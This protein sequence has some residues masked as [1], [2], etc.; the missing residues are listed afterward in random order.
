MDELIDIVNN[1]DDY[2]IL[3]NDIVNRIEQTNNNI[4]MIKESAILNIYWNIGETL[5]EMGSTSEEDLK[6]IRDDPLLCHV[7]TNTHWLRLAKRWV[8][9]HYHYD[10]KIM[11]SGSVT[12]VQWALLLECVN[13]APQRYWLACQAIKQKWDA[14]LL[15]RAV[16]ALPEQYLNFG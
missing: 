8:H 1:T 5:I 4:D 3:Y 15:L 10:K 9:E 2:T 6:L 11:L 13:S 14:I 16:Q 7:S 12:W